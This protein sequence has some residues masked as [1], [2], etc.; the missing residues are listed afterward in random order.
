MV[1]SGVRTVGFIGFNDPYGDKITT[2]STANV[3]PDG[4]STPASTTTKAV[5]AD[6]S[7]QTTTVQ[8]TPD[9]T[10]TT[11]QAVGSNSDDVADQKGYD[12]KASAD[13]SYAKGY[14]HRNMQ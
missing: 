4:K 2:T 5:N 12:P 8:Q 7:T 6:G 13:D 1:K 9:G 14:V 3:G 11:N 10:K